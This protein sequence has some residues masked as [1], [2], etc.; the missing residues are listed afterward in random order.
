MIP[1]PPGPGDIPLPP[2]GYRPIVRTN[3]PTPLVMQA[4]EEID[5]LKRGLA[6]LT[7]RLEALEGRVA[8]LEA[9]LKG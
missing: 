3:D 9:S 4:M 6:D 5:A 2:E 7:K 8:A 1:S